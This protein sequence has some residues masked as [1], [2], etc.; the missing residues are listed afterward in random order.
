MSNYYRVTAYH[1]NEDIS[2]IVDSNGRFE[3][4]WELSAHLI[5]K[6]FDILEVAKEENIIEA[7]FP[8]IMKPSNKII[9]RSVERG[10]PEIK[11]MLYEGRNC[12]SV[13]LC[14]HVYGIYKN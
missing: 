10:K 3:K 12:K 9:L 5:A 7:T 8:K 2:V 11:E 1:P 4:L 6:G 13:I 14:K